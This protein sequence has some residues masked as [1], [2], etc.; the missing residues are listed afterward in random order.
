MMLAVTMRAPIQSA[1]GVDG[2]A[3]VRQAIDSYVQGQEG[4]TLALD[5]S[6]DTAPIN[7]PPPL[8]ADAGSLL[9]AIRSAVNAVGGTDSLLLLG[10]DSVIPLFQINNP[11][12]D[13][14][15][16]PDSAIPSD[17]P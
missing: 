13:R 9:I 16:D 2:Y 6:D 5:D 15:I 1:F 10:N 12:K 8:A 7:I 17:D 14:T 3:K 4:K 11:V